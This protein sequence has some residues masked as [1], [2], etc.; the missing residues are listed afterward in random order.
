MARY[1]IPSTPFAV[2]GG[3]IRDPFDHEQIVYGTQTLGAERTLIDNLFINGDGIV[4]GVSVGYGYDTPSTI[5][6]EVAFTDGFRS[7]NMNF[8]DFST[9]NAD[10]VQ[11]AGSSGRQQA[12]GKTIA[13]SPRVEP[14][15]TCWSSA[16]ASITPR[17]ATPLNSSM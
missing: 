7:S 5:R 6:S 15:T 12:T 16:P 11:R 8:Q 4:Q 14:P 13:T 3:Q 9:T 17:P 10:W 2:R 1:H